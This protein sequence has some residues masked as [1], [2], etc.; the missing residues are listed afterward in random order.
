[1]PVPA[2]PTTAA[3]LDDYY[4]NAPRGVR[5]N[6]IF[7][8]DGAGAFAGRTKQI[9]DPADQVL[10]QRLRV[11]ADVVLVGAGTVR[12]ERYG[13]VR[14][15]D[16][17]VQWR[18]NNGYA[19]R[20]PLAIVTARAAFA[21][22]A[23]VFDPQ[24]PRTI[25]VTTE[26]GAEAAHRLDEVADVVVAGDD[27]VDPRVMIEALAARGLHRVL[28]E[29]GPFLLSRLVEHDLVD[30]MC[31]TLSPYLAGSQPLTPEPPSARDQPTR[32][33][34][35]HILERDGLLYLRYSRPHAAAG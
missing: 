34:L 2:L 31:L 10:L 14:F 26:R 6:M 16:E 5:A 7:T 20:P 32:L 21:A 11:H 30:D 4:G 3:E 15:S 18:T 9:T 35:R 13:P 12:A 22:D 29:G 23:K 19:A 27:L 8:V 33:A 17:E 25:L 28:C 1:M 24:A